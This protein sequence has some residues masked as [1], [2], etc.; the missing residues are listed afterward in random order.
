[1]KIFV[2]WM[3]WMKLSYTDM[4]CPIVSS[5]KTLLDFNMNGVTLRQS[6]VTLLLKHWNSMLLILLLLRLNCIKQSIR[7]LQIREW[8]HTCIRW[9]WIP[10]IQVGISNSFISTR[11]I[12]DEN[13]ILS[14]LIFWRRLITIIRMIA[15]WF[16]VRFKSFE[17]EIVDWFEN[18]SRSILL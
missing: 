15:H 3:D 8:V 4:S 12:S 17:G 16:L 14:E 10:L 2:L 11:R 9:G 7:F 1:M 18:T 13:V 5:G 6:M